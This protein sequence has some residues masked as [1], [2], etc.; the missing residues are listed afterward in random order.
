MPA[1]RQSAARHGIGPCE[2]EVQLEDAG[3][4]AIAPEG[5]GVPSREAR[6]GD[7]Q[8]LPRRE[9]ENHGSGFR[10]LVQ[11][12]HVRAGDDLAAE[13]PEEGSQRLRD[14]VRAPR[15]NGHPKTW[16]SVPRTRPAAA[17]VARSSGN[18]E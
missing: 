6:T 15:G 1:R 3:A 7:R 8:H 2:R 17:V 16:P 14:V 10:E 11:A 9:V 4:V 18:T 13:S 5:A 12:R